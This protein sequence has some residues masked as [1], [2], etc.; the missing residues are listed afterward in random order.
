[1]LRVNLVDDILIVS[2]NRRAVRPLSGQLGTGPVKHRHKVITHHM[3]VF[4]AQAFQR[5]DVVVNIAV[6]VLCPCLD[7][8]MDVD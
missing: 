3:N 7:V 1:M 8:V 5:R 2:E 6:S 4:L